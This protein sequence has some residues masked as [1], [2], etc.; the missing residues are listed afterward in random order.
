MISFRPMQA[1]E[2]PAYCDYFVPDYAAEIVA[3]Y[4]LPE[5][6]ALSRARREL[7]E[8]LPD[9]PATVGHFLLCITNED[10]GTAPVIG[11]L[12]YRAQ[13]EG[14]VARILDFHIL[15]AVQ[16]Q[17]YGKRALEALEARLY[18]EGY[19]EMRLRVAADNARAH[20]IYRA[21][22]FHATGINMAKRIAGPDI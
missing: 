2:F 9:G 1:H 21:Q 22:G 17:G 4:R 18:A 20:D 11:Y 8:D 5:P 12:W 6:E 16:G 13:V 14:K 7:V 15:D 19:S 3:N 10:T